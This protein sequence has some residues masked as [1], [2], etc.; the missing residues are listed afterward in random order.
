MNRIELESKAVELKI[1]FTAETSDQQ[2]EEMV[3]SAQPATSDKAAKG[4]RKSLETKA[5]KLKIEFTAETSD[6]LLEAKIDAAQAKSDLAEAKN[7]TKEPAEVAKLRKDLEEATEL[8]ARVNAKLATNEKQAELK[9]A[10]PMIT[11]GDK[12][13]ICTAARFIYMHEKGKKA[14]NHVEN[15]VAGREVATYTIKDLQENE[16]LAKEIIESGS[17]ILITEEQAAER[18]AKR[19]RR[20]A[21][22]SHFLKQLLTKKED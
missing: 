10:L 19:Q 18:K 5:T 6:E 22:K 9:T 11:V 20:L 17:Q 13:Y 2:L 4:A 15:T 14:V 7:G 16:D 3:A 12:S 8:N 21:G 1:E